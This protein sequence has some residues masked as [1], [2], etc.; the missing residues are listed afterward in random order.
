MCSYFKA[1]QQDNEASRRL[2][3]IGIEMSYPLL[4]VL[5]SKGFKLQDKQIG[6]KSP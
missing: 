3:D 6:H 4:E 1:T 2:N 5:V